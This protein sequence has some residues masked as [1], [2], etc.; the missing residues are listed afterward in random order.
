MTKPRTGT[1]T[2]KR[3]T[4]YKTLDLEAAGTGSEALR[5]APT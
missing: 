1:L 5:P 3:L 2:G 4:T